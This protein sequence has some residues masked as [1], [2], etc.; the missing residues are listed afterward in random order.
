[1]N[2]QAT[3][4]LPVSIRTVPVDASGRWLAAAWLDIRRAPGLSIGYGAV[5]VVVS[6]ALSFG[7]AA[8]DLGS[9][10]L[11]L[12]GG[13]V[14]IAPLLVVGFYEISRRHESGETPT[15]GTIAR[16]SYANFGQAGAMGTVLMMVFLV[17]TLL[18]LVIFALFYGQNPPPLDRF[19]EE[20]VFSVRGAM[21]LALGTAVEAVLA[22]LIFTISAFSFPLLV[23]R[24]V[25]V[26]TAIA[27]SAAAVR[28]NWQVMFGWAALIVILTGVGFFTL[29]FGLAVVM[30]LLGC[31]AWHAY[32]DVIRPH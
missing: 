16:A 24:P 30:P 27:I 17:W 4:G 22:A 19:V 5:F 3:F 20:I 12:M 32:R 9:L 21:F 11:P 31:A 23:D 8:L 7:L 13:F 10:I 25:D 26:V 1:M 18:A 6:F 2:P 29:F 28:T 15:L 14:L